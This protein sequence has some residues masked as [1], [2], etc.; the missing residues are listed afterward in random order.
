MLDSIFDFDDPSGRKS[1]TRFVWRLRLLDTPLF[2]LDVVRHV[3][4]G[5]PVKLKR[6]LQVSSVVGGVSEPYVSSTYYLLL[7]M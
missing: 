4:L 6:E 7:G 2:E 3:G 5:F 1:F